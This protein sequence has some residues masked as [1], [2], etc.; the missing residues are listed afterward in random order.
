MGWRCAVLSTVPEMA[1]PTKRHQ[2]NDARL[3]MTAG[4]GRYRRS[5][6]RRSV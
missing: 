2:P 4:Q 6:R 3:T 1:R 5:G